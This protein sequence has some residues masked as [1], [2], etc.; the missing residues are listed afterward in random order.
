LRRLS[1]ALNA[2]LGAPYQHRA[3]ETSNQNHDPKPID[4]GAQLSK[5]D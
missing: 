4:P 5:R 3:A 2:I 1:L